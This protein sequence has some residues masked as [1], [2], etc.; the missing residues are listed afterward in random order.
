MTHAPL[1]SQVYSPPLR[2]CAPNSVFAPAP[3]C[4]T[5]CSGWWR[6]PAGL[7]TLISTGSLYEKTKERRKPE[8]KEAP[9][10]VSFVFFVHGGA[11]MVASPSQDGARG[12]VPLDIADGAVSAFGRIVM[13]AVPRR[14]RSATSGSTPQRF[15]VP[16]QYDDNG[17]DVSIIRANLRITPTE[18]ARRGAGPRRR[19]PP[20]HVGSS[21][22]QRKGWYR[23]PQADQAYTKAA[24][25]RSIAGNASFSA[26]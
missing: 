12:R 2:A 1:A 6:C 17:V 13:M 21:A 8:P 23:C 19:G 26:Q 25:S 20:A 4:P 18:R 11:H 16:G 15:G 5:I 14:D 10:F 22:T 3:S 7:G 9:F 24:S